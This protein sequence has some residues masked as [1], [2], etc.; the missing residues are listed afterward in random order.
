[1]AEDAA[2]VQNRVDQ[3]HQ[4]T[5]D[6]KLWERMSDHYTELDLLFEVLGKQ[7]KDLTKSAQLVPK[8][9]RGCQAWLLANRLPEG[10]STQ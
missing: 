3:V 9:Q 8:L 1:M 7:H 5:M 6:K 4:D 10:I 2:E